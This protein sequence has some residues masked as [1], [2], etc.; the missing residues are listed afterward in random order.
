MLLSLSTIYT[1][2]DGKI[3]FNMSQVTTS[4]SSIRIDLNSPI[5]DVRAFLDEDSLNYPLFDNGSITSILTRESDWV[6]DSSNAWETDNGIEGVYTFTAN[7]SFDNPSVYPDVDRSI[8]TVSISVTVST[9]APTSDV[10]DITFDQN[11]LNEFVIETDF[12]V[13]DDTTIIGGSSYDV[14]ENVQ[15]DFSLLM[16]LLL[17]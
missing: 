12:Y 4:P 5:E 17:S 14:V 11:N 1:N 3:V 7:F 15:G 9:V 10:T 6:Y 16:L 2:L 13:E 8:T